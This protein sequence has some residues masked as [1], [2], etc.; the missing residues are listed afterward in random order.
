MEGP[1]ALS[2]HLGLDEVVACGFSHLEPPQRLRLRKRGLD[3]QAGGAL[4]QLVDATAKVGLE[5]DAMETLKRAPLGV[6]PAHPRIELLKRKG[7]ALSNARIP[8]KVRHG[9]RRGLAR[10]GAPSSRGGAAHEV[11][12]PPTSSAASPTRRHAP[13]VGGA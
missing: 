6:D 1:A 4:Q 13:P 2:V 5:P 3:E 8:A 12:R 9:G 10:R 7:L 11:P